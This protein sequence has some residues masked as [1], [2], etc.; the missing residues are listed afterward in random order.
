MLGMTG[1]SARS[2]ATALDRLSRK[3]II[4]CGG[5]GEHAK[6]GT[7]GRDLFDSV[8][9]LYRRCGPHVRK[10]LGSGGKSGNRGCPGSVSTSRNGGWSA[11]STFPRLCQL[12]WVMA[13]I[14][15]WA[16]RGKSITPKAE[17]PGQICSR[18]GSRLPRALAAAGWI[19]QNCADAGH[20][21]HCHKHDVAGHLN[22]LQA[23]WESV[24]GHCLSEYKNKNHRPKAFVDC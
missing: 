16:W 9:A 8:G 18:A 19:A 2:M 21:C 12:R 14:P 3:G 1:D 20:K 23:S 15:T 10:L 7:S 17:A 4:L 11:A 6:G 24:V 22:P 5:S 13:R